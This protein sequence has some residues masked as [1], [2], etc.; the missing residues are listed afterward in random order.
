MEAHLTHLWF[1]CFQNH[2]SEHY[3]LQKQLKWSSSPS[4]P[5]VMRVKYSLNQV[6]YFCLSFW[7]A[8]LAF[9]LKLEDRC[10]SKILQ[11]KFS[12]WI[13]DFKRIWVWLIHSASPNIKICPHF[14]MFHWWSFLTVEIRLSQYILYIIVLWLMFHEEQV[15]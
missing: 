10:K 6:I 14:I 8:G 13:S 2:A 11:K 7:M 12:S 5:Y 9:M 4:H 15:I 1:G 3:N